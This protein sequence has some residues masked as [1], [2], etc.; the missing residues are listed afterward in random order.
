M[1]GRG[2]CVAFRVRTWLMNVSIKSLRNVSVQTS[3]GVT[4][5]DGGPP[6]DGGGDVGDDSGLG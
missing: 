4:F 2:Y 5:K 1:G 3:S 6:E